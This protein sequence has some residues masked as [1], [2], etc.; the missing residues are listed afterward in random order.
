MSM[1]GYL[2]ITVY[3]NVESKTQDSEPTGYAQVIY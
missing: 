3:E 2:S 1:T